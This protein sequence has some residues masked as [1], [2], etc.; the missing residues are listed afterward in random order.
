[1]QGASGCQPGLRQSDLDS[2]GD[3]LGRNWVAIIVFLRYYYRKSNATS[4]NFDPEPEPSAQ[5]K[6]HT[7]RFM[8]SNEIPISWS[9][10]EKNS[11]AADN[12]VRQSPVACASD[13]AK[14]HGPYF[15]S[16]ISPTVNGQCQA[17]SGT[18][19]LYR[20]AAFQYRR[21]KVLSG[22]SKNSPKQSCAAGQTAHSHLT[23]DPRDRLF[24]YLGSSP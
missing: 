14:H 22:A 12:E 17:L 13:P 18:A 1:M 11:T 15:E 4:P 2:G 21:L 6:R 24:R 7:Q 9:I 3:A 23:I 20:A 16:P 19:P 5:L 10:P 8:D